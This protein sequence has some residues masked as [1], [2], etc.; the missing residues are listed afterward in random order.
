MITLAAPLASAQAVSDVILAPGGQATVLGGTITGRA[1]V[2]YRLE[3]RAGQELHVDLKAPQGGERGSAYLNILPPGSTDVAIYIGSMDDDGQET[4]RLPEDG[5][6]TLRLY[7]RGNDRDA[8][9]TVA[10]VLGLS[11]R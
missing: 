4:L 9:E 7:L 8:G 5:A 11:L 10:Y 6:Y 1:H 2:D 3:A